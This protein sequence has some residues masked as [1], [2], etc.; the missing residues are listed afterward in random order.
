MT[1]AEV[2]V[3]GIVSIVA[4]LVMAYSNRRLWK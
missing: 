1:T 2:I 3:T 4:L